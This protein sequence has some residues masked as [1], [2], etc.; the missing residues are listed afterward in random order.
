[1][2]PELVSGTRWAHYFAHAPFAQFLDNLV[3][4]GEY[5]A[6]AQDPH[7]DGFDVI[8]ALSLSR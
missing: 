4:P 6:C 7:K 5:Q 8:T 1:M 3:A 2:F